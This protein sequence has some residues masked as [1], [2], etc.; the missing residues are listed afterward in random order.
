[1]AKSF[2][3]VCV[4]CSKGTN[5]SV[6]L[7]DQA[8]RERDKVALCSRHYRQWLDL[9]ERYWKLAIQEFWKEGE[10]DE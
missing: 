3:F 2:F 1:M 8:G 5:N 6:Y 7:P 4:K 9:K 10:K